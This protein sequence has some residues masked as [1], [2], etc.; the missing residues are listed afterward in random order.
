MCVQTDVFGRTL[1]ISVRLT[2]LYTLVTLAV[3]MFLATL[4]YW[5]I[6]DRFDSNHVHFLQA[7]IAE[8]ETDLRDGHGRPEV[9]LDEMDCEK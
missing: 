8:Q 5:K 1:S 4:V 7:K 9:L 2:T 3:I 6:S